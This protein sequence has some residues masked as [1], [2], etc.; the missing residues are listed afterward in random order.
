M[1]NLHHGL[2]PKC[3]RKLAYDLALAEQVTANKE[4]KK[5]Q[6]KKKKSVIQIN[7]P[8]LEN[9]EEEET[10]KEVKK[11]GLNRNSS[12]KSQLDDTLKPCKIQ[13]KKNKLSESN[14]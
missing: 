5:F 6:R 10:L 9:L 2:N 4:N 1:A 12:D 8:V 3:A 7:T 14:S 11:S 13:K